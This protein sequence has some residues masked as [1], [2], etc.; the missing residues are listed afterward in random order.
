FTF[1]VTNYMQYAMDEGTRAAI[2][3]SASERIQHLALGIFDATTN[4]L[5]APVQIQNKK[6]QGYGSFTAKLNYGKYRLVF[7]GYGGSNSI[8]IMENP[9]EISFGSDA[10]PQTFLSSFEFTVDPNTA[11][12]T[13][14]V[15]KRVVSGFKLTMADAISSR[16]SG[17]K[18]IS[19]GGG[20]VLNAKTG[21]AKA[22]TGRENT[23]VIPES[24]HGKTGESVIFYLFLP[25][26]EESMDI[27]ASAVDENGE[28][29]IERTFADVPMKI[30]TLTIYQGNFFADTPYGFSI[31]MEDD[32][33][34]EV[35]NS[36]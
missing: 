29:F 27:T 17:I 28:A 22:S 32:W 35:T 25:A 20:M 23:I 31:T 3:P 26:N 24:Y 30:N 10:L 16:T 8:L 4:T 12:T 18:F 15:L 9:E 34:E 36:F 1:Q 7:L 21:L 2:A 6:D 13:N 33:G 5:V 11:A 14:V 19:T